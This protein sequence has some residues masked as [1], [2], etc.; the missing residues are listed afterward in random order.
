MY[1]AEQLLDAQWAKYQGMIK[2]NAKLQI[3]TPSLEDIYQTLIKQ[4]DILA[5]ERAKIN[6]LKTKIAS[7][8]FSLQ[9]ASNV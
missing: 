7:K 3:H 8:G 1:T 4:K 9:K 2:R 6:Y 5:R